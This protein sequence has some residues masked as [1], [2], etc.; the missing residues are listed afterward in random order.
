LE[1]ARPKKLSLPDV[2]EMME[3]D[4]QTRAPGWAV[5]RVVGTGTIAWAFIGVWLIATEPAIG[6]FSAKAVM[7]LGVGMIAAGVVLSGP[8]LADAFTRR[9][10]FRLILNAGLIFLVERWLF[11]FLV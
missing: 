8:K 10:F 11:G 1:L 2:G 7:F 6:L 3:H 4:S 9:G 5:T